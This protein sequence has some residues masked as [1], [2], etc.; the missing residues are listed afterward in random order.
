MAHDTPVYHLQDGPAFLFDQF[1]I[2]PLA[3][4]SHFFCLLRPGNQQKDKLVV[5]V[6]FAVRLL[7]YSSGRQR[8]E[9]LLRR[10]LL[11]CLTPLSLPG[12]NLFCG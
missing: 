11:P 1:H 9:R 10:G 3:A 7:L 2:L 12:K 4:G 6:D 8:G 5:D